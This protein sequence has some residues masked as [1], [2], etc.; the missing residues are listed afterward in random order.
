[1]RLSRAIRKYVAMKQLLGAPFNHGTQLLHAFHTYVGGV[2]LRSVAK[3]HVLGFLKRSGLSDVTWL[4][5]YRL[6]R[7]FFEYWMARGELQGLPIPP[8]RHPGTARTFVPYI[9]SVSD[10]RKLLAGTAFRRTPN[11][12]EFSPLTFRTVLLFLYGTG[13]RINETLRL[14]LSDVDLRRGTVTFGR[15]TA[16]RRRVVPIGLHLCRTLQDYVGSLESTG[17]N[18]MNFFARKNG[19]PIRPVDLCRS[20]RTLRLKA[21]ISRPADIS[22]QPRVQDLRWTFAVH[23]MRAWLGRGKDLRSM[24]PI[25]G[26]YLGHVSLASTEAYLAVTPERFLIQL[27]HLSSADKT[28]LHA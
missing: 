22:R 4:L 18:R 14:K 3:W 15:Y 16:N 8:S 27:S 10:L 9:Y 17:G 21:G 7:A 12:R 26:A 19:R 2:S 23:C 24:L 28:Q 20:F 5:R 6:L 13:A 25:L 1:M 11:S